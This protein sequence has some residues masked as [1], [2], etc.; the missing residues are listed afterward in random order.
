[1]NETS[2]QK[3]KKQH[4]A[5]DKCKN[6]KKINNSYRFY[7]KPPKNTFCVGF[8]MFVFFFILKGY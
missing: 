3:K 8:T 2:L 5:R 1:M 6:N 4:T 7:S